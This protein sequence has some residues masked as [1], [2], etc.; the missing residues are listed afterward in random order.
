MQFYSHTPCSDSLHSIM[1]Q[2]NVWSDVISLTETFQY[3]PPIPLFE[4]LRK[5][6]ALVSLKSFMLST[7]PKIK[8]LVK[9]LFVIKLKLQFRGR[10]K[11]YVV[12][13]CLI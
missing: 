3:P 13:S 7:E 1:L 11:Y 10:V 5:R 8:Y 12:E 6:K 9:Y 4:L 2:N